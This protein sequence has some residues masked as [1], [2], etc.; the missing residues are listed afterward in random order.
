[1]TFKIDESYR[2]K[3]LAAFAAGAKNVL[4]I[5]CSQYPNIYLKNES[6][7]GLDINPGRVPGN[8]TRFVTGNLALLLEEKKTYEAIVAGEVL[9]HVENP[10]K[11]LKECNQLLEK[12][13]L[14][15]LSTPNPHSII[16]FFLTLLI[17]K[18]YFYTKDHVMIYPQRWLIRLLD[19]SGFTNTLLF[20]GGFP[21]PPLGL[22]PFPRSLCYQTIAVCRK[23]GEI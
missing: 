7:T 13:G 19:L 14:L 22:I 17:N 5:G 23:K 8:Y 21:L 3:K 9:E 12:E 10:L 6:V 20:S 15:I 16:E 11:F 18:K 2:L 1:M 4:D